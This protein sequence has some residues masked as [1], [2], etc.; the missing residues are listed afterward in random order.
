MPVNFNFTPPPRSNVASKIMGMMRQNPNPSPGQSS[1][2]GLNAA[3]VSLLKIQRNQEIQANEYAV[4]LLSNVNSEEDL[5]IAKRMYTSRYPEYAGQVD[6]LLPVYTPD[7]VEFIRESL[8]TATTKLREQELA[9]DRDKLSASENKL[10]GFAPGTDIYQDG[11]LIHHVPSRTTPQ[12]DVF[13]GPEGNQVYIAKGSKIPQGY[14]KVGGRGITIQTGVGSV[15][16]STRTQLE[17]SIIEGVKSIQSF[18]VTRG[19]FDPKY[20]QWRGKAQN[21]VASIMDKAG[22]STVE[23]RKFL[24]KRAKWFRRAKADFIAY[25]KW[26][27]GVAGGPQ[28]LKEI[29]TSFP[30]PV[31]NSPSQYTANLD[32]VED[33]TKQVLMLNRD[34]LESGIDLSQPLSDIIS[35]M[36]NKGLNVPVPPTVSPK[37][38]P[39][40]GDTVIRFDKNGNLIKD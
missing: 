8:K 24:K 34:F 12:Y 32:S 18:K 23:Q 5:Q 13:K 26:A 31:S 10:Q 38:T 37:T 14:S 7:R 11:K 17:K 15:G 21:E 35:K 9:L 40:K 16:K 22:I 2:P 27:T 30:D 19:N 4:N 39:P 3:Q 25:R 28:E 20:L 29:A 33:T 1:S 36:K 6:K